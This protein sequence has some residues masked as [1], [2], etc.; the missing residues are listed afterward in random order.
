MT[1]GDSQLIVN[2]VKRSFKD[3]D[4]MKA[5]YPTE[6]HKLIT[7]F[8]KF[9]ILQVPQE[10]NVHADTSVSLASNYAIS[11]DSG[12]MIEILVCPK[13]LNLP[14]FIGRLADPPLSVYPLGKQRVLSEIHEG[15]RGEHIIERTLAF[16]VLRQGYYQLTLKKKS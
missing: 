11:P 4:A 2:Q 15:L 7:C 13:S 9:E 1:F 12:L 14:T 5:R 16:K 8:A 10:E 6:V 3:Q